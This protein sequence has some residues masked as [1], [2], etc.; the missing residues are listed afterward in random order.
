ME[1]TEGFTEEELKKLNELYETVTIGITDCDELESISD[2]ILN[3]YPSN[4]G[5]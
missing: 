4:I 5:K 1:N 3:G 2:S